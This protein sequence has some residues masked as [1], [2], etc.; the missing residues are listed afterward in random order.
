MTLSPDAFDTTV[1]RLTEG[2]RGRQ[3]TNTYVGVYYYYDLPNRCVIGFRMSEKNGLTID[4][5]ES[6]FPDQ[7]MTRTKFHK[8]R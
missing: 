5:I 8:G 4:V 7:L 3:P 1:L 2:L 6:K